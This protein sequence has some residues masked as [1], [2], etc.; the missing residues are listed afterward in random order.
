[1]KITLMDICAQEFPLHITKK[2]IHELNMC[3]TQFELRGDNPLVFNTDMLGVH[4]AHFVDQ[5]QNNFFE[6]MDVSYQEF[7]RKIS[8]C[9]TINKKFKVQR[10]PYNIFTIWVIHNILNSKELSGKDIAVGAM[11]AGTLM[12]Y[13]FF[14]SLVNHRFPYKVNEDIMRYTIDN[15]SGKYLIKQKDTNTWKKL[16]TRRVEELIL[17]PKSIHAKT[18]KHFTPDDKIGYVITDLQSRIRDNVNNITREFHLNKEHG[19]KIGTYGLVDEIGGDKTLRNIVDS[20]SVVTEKVSAIILNVGKLMDPDLIK[21]VVKLNGNLRED[22][23]RVLLTSFSNLA[24]LQYKKHKQDEEIKVR[25]GV[26]FVGYRILIEHII[27][28]TFRRCLLKG[29]D[30]KSK[31]AILEATKNMYS[32]SRIADEDILKVKNSVEYFVDNHTHINRE[33]T[34]TSLKLGFILYI[35]LLAMKEA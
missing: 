3:L 22:M 18:L 8:A 35:I 6:I 15:L 12:V 5:D 21:L 25:D 13:R 19:D 16:I 4:L 10:N 28:K 34:K 2:T 20:F 32:H 1:M 23:F 17:E 11:A 14:T 33:Q 24:L 9:N 7:A 31:L 30:V 29:I 26:V 27:Q